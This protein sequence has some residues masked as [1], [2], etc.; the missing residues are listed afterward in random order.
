MSYC[1]KCGTYIENDIFLCQKCGHSSGTY[2]AAG[3]ERHTPYIR[4]VLKRSGTPKDMQ[5]LSKFD[6]FNIITSVLL[7]IFAFVMA[8]NYVN[9]PTWSSDKGKMGALTLFL[10]LLAL[11]P[12]PSFAKKIKVAQSFLCVCEEGI[13]GRTIKGFP[14]EVEYSCI[15]DVTRNYGASNLKGMLA[16]DFNF[17]C[18]KN[19]VLIICGPYTYVCKRLFRNNLDWRGC[20]IIFKS[21][22][23]RRIVS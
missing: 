20:S 12:I 14:F 17:R 23:I 3:A 6:L 16:K 11:Y 10:F 22:D 21:S 1:S 7:L 19:S 2:G 18:W 9:E 8:Y 5:A 15:S 13:Y 4:T